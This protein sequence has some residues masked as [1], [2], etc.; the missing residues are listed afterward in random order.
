VGILAH[1]AR[2]PSLAKL[3]CMVAWDESLEGVLVLPNGSTV[4]GLPRRIAF[5]LTPP[6]ELLVR[7]AGRRPVQ[8]DPHQ[9]W[10]K[11]PD[12]RAPTD[13]GQALNELRTAFE[14]CAEERVL[15]SCHGGIG[16]TGT[17]LTV[18][19]ML[20]GMRCG[21]AVEWVRERYS[22]RAVE[23]VFQR[24]WLNTVDDILFA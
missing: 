24:R 1:V 20:A 13:T 6:P 8:D 11:W 7:L 9:R 15:I 19:V 21:C 14:R 22:P 17:A 23:T 18:M 3:C 12:F 4:R 2:A 5:Q 10:I 16:R